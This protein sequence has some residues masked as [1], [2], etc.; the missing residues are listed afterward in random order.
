LVPYLIMLMVSFYKTQFPS[1]VPAF[2]FDSYVRVFAHPQYVAVLLR[3]LKIAMLVSMVTFVLAYPV[4][5]F[6]VFMVRSG[7]V[8]MMI[9]VAIVV[10]LWV[11]Y[12]LRVYAW[13]IILGTNG[14]LNT[15]LMW[16]GVIDQPIEILLYNQYA[17]IITMAYIFTPFMVMPIFAALEKI[18]RSLIEGSNDLGVGHGETF[19]RITLPLSMPGVLV[20]F[21]FTFCFAFGDFISPRLV[22]G[23]DSN[24]IA[25][26]IATQFGQAMDWPFGSALSVVMLFIVLG[27]ISVS[28]R[29][30]SGG[31]INLGSS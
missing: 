5:Y 2:E 31:R 20:G 4:A 19:L 11:S 17:M 12:L 7:R 9:Y 3:S 24:M 1:H 27:I 29:L 30:E 13:K 26:V 6:L 18:P 14:I 23:P 25:N 8:R 21:T 15:L 28:D 16:L 22:G 10:P